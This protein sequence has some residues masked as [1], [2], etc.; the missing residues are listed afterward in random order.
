MTLLNDRDRMMSD[1]AR[2]L[3]AP[4]GV[5]YDHR[6]LIAQPPADVDQWFDQIVGL[7][8][9]IG[10]W[11]RFTYMGTLAVRGD[12]LVASKLNFELGD[13]GRLD[14]ILVTRLD[15]MVERTEVV[16]QYDPEQLDEALAK[17]DHLHAE[18]GV[19]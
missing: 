11:P 9:L 19:D 18:L 16:H 7:E 8:A 15:E 10:R 14:Y 17:L 3:F 5:R 6:R 1:K 12:R 4:G 2:G 13:L